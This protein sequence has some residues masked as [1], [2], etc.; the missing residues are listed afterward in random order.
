MKI[1]K[2]LNA[3]VPVILNVAI[4]AFLIALAWIADLNGKTL[5]QAAA[6]DAKFATAM[7]PF[8]EDAKSGKKKETVEHLLAVI[9][10]VTRA[11]SASSEGN[12]S[13]AES[14]EA[15]KSMIIGVIVLQ[16]I[17]TLGYWR[18]NKSLQSTSAL[19]RRRD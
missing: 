7:Q 17:L 16:L 4:L 13:L 5:H 12:K 15:M 14:L 3:V 19:T 6:Q 8:I 1:I 2:A 9:E 11:A 18:Y 10:H